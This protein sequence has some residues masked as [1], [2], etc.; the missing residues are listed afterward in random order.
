[1]YLGYG[2]LDTLVPPSTNGLVMAARYA[3]LG[4][5]HQAPFDQVET[6]GHT[7]DIAGVNVTR[8]DA[9]VDGV[10]AGAGST[11]V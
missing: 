8:L 5:A 4:K 1:M 10:R 7:I 11:R 2:D 6:Q 9:F 3:D